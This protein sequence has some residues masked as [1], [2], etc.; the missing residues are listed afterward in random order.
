MVLLRKCFGVIYYKVMRQFN[1]NQLL[2]T[3]VLLLGKTCTAY[4]VSD[5]EEKGVITTG[6]GVFIVAHLRNSPR[7]GARLRTGCMG[8]M[9][10]G[11][12]ALAG[13]A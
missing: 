11:P 1:L 3:L 12:A 13:T 5:E 2:C 10:L 9:G 6:Q 8:P 4:H 7:E